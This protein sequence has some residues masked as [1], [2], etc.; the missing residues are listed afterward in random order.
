MASRVPF[1]QISNRNLGDSMVIYNRSLFSLHA[2]WLQMIS[3]EFFGRFEWHH[4][5]SS[6]DGNYSEAA[7]NRSDVYRSYNER[8]HSIAV[9]YLRWPIFVGAHHQ[10]PFW[11]LSLASWWNETYHHRH[12]WH[13]GENLFWNSTAQWFLQYALLSDSRILFSQILVQWQL[14]KIRTK[15]IDEWM[16]GTRLGA[17]SLYLSMIE[18]FLSSGNQHHRST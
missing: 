8:H 11:P 3:I 10:F 9:K 4:R 1:Q 18:Q 14:K 2:N 12:V 13:L 7:P 6:Y 5:L 17:R 15:T 16:F